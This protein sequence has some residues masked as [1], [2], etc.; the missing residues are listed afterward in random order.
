MEN[1]ETV[2]ADAY[3]ERHT[4]LPLRDLEGKAIG[5]VDIS[6]GEMKQLPSHENKEAQRMLRLLQKAVKEIVKESQGEE[7]KKILGKGH[8]HK[9]V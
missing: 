4:A 5:V 1:S 7:K 9:C 8:R 3:G 2:C 6:I